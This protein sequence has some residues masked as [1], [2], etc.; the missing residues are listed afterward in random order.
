MEGTRL[1]SQND[2]SDIHRPLSVIGVVIPDGKCSLRGI[3][4]ERHSIYRMLSQVTRF[5]P[6][7]RAMSV[8][9]VYVSEPQGV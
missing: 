3:R 7:T 8:A 5:D 1:G 6:L 2:A 4:A 9:E